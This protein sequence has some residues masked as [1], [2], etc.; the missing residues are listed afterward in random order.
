VQGHGSWPT[1]NPCGQVLHALDEE[2]PCIYYNTWMCHLP[3]GSFLTEV[4]NDQFLDVL[5]EFYDDDAVEARNKSP[6]HSLSRSPTEAAPLRISSSNRSQAIDILPIF[7]ISS[8]M[9]HL[10]SKMQYKVLKL[11]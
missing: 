6:L 1:T 3:E 2:L 11:S 5:K 7:Y 10:P 4:G 9:L 8:L